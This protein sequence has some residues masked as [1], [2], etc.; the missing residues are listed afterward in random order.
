MDKSTRLL[1]P[2][3]G[4]IQQAAIVDDEEETGEDDEVETEPSPDDASATG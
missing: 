2:M 1:A 3:L 4:G